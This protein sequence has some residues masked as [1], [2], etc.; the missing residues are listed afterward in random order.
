ML[1]LRSSVPPHSSIHPT[2]NCLGRH[3]GISKID[4]PPS[5]ARRIGEGE[6]EISLINT[7]RKLGHAPRLLSDRLRSFFGA[8]LASLDLACAKDWSLGTAKASGLRLRRSLRCAQVQ[9]SEQSPSYDSSSDCAEASGPGCARARCSGCA[10][11]CD[12]HR[13]E[14]SPSN[15]WNLKCV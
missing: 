6:L 5:E 8:A 7:T 14:L 1:A 15:Y 13:N 4:P 3:W 2:T 11:A 10:Q 12:Y 9:H